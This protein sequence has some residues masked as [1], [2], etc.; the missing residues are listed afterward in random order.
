MLACSHGEHRE[1]YSK[2]SRLAAANFDA[3]FP[4]MGEDVRRL[5]QAIGPIL[6]NRWADIPKHVA[7]NDSGY[8]CDENDYDIIVTI[9]ASKRG[10]AALFRTPGAVDGP[11]VVCI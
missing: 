11:K 10:F 7:S 8:S 6:E 2:V 5:G 4:I 1:L 3:P 9:D